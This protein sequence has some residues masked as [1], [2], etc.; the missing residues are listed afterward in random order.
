MHSSIK[1]VILKLSGEGLSSNNTIIDL[2]KL[3]L[4]SDIILEFISKD[5]CVC[6]V[7]GGGNIVRGKSFSKV[8]DK[9]IAD[10]AG[11]LSTYINGL[12]IKDILANSKV[13]SLLFSDK[14]IDWIGSS[15]DIHAAYKAYDSRIPIISAGGIGCTGVSTDTAA[16]LR[17]IQL[18]AD[19]IVKF[20]QVDGVY[21]KDPN[22]S[23]DA[24]RFSSVDLD[25]AI[26]EELQIM[27]LS[28]LALCKSNNKKLF[29]CKPS[30][31]IVKN[32]LEKDFSKGTIVY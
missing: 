11:M 2:E 21:N 8:S 27:D 7:I 4:Y 12:F 28:A 25:H 20:T 18:D 16:A 31:G 6:I 9:T 3:Q 29:V 5:I 10:Y 30:L 19:L 14:S 15:S 26:K 24:I 23:K 32:I 17:A 22:I 13:E 1:K